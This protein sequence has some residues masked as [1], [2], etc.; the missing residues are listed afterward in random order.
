MRTALAP[1]GKGFRFAMMGLDGG[2]PE[3]RRLRARRRPAGFRDRQVAYLETRHQFGKALKENQA[4][5]FRLADMAT[6]L[7]AGRA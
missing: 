1:K 2:Q 3:Y 7:E 4:L 5:Q 6:E